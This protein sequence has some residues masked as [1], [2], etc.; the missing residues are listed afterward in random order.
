M[1]ILFTTSKYPTSWLIRKVTGDDCS[2]V[3]MEKGGIVIHS[4][5]TGLRLEPLHIFKQR[6]III[7]SV[8][9]PKPVKFSKIISDYWGAKYDFKGL[10]YLGIRYILPKNLLAKG[11]L[12]QTS[13]MFLCTELVTDILE[14]REDS[15][16]TP[17]E[18]YR[19]LIGE[20]NVSN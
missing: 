6:N 13:G 15:T 4:D 10:L 20:K 12:W 3:A 9:S 19:R 7:H 8:S 2:H 11:N 5:F 17:H 1:N 18:L 14:D 16:I